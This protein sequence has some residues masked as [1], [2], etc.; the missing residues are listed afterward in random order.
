MPSVFASDRLCF[1]HPVQNSC[2]AFRVLH[3]YLRNTGKKYY[4]DLR[5]LSLVLP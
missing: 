1:D 4:A 2:G 5:N 3:Q